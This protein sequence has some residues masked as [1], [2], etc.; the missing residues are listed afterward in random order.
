MSVHHI[1][2]YVIS[3]YLITGD[4]NLDCLVKVRSVW[5]LHCNI[6]TNLFFFPSGI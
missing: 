1:K 6:V 4:V 3:M 2:R 5:F